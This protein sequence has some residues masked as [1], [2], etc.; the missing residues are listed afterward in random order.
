MLR[1][2]TRMSEMKNNEVG[3]EKEESIWDSF[4]KLPKVDRIEEK[5]NNDLTDEKKEFRWF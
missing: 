5:E 4:W 3:K 2:G 1:G